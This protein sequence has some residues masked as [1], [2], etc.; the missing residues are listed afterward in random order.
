MARAKGPHV[1]F[2]ALWVEI[3]ETRYTRTIKTRHSAFCARSIHTQPCPI[4]K[5]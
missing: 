4:N 5:P 3:L 1:D 2:W